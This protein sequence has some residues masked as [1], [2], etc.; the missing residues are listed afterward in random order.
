MSA[1]IRSSCKNTLIDVDMREDKTK[2]ILLS[3]DVEHSRLGQRK[4]L[5]VEFVLLTA[6]LI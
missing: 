6:G 1:L 3:S 5:T 2:L 4:S